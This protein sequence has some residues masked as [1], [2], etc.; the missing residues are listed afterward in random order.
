ML[1]VNDGAAL[2]LTCFYAVCSFS[3]IPVENA[4]NIVNDVF[5]A[6]K[7]RAASLNVNLFRN[8]RVF[9]SLDC[10][11][12]LIF[13]MCTIHKPTAWLNRLPIAGQRN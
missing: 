6:A 8:S 9:R 1:A 7:S 3:H 10:V 2:Y 13:K 11:R 5:I 12:G 4:R